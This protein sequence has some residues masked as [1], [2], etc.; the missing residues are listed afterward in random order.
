M[1]N[2][3]KVISGL[4]ILAVIIIGL[5]VWLA[6]RGPTSDRYLPTAVNRAVQTGDGTYTVGDLVNEGD[7]QD[8][9]PTATVTLVELADFE[10]PVCQTVYPVVASLRDQFTTDQLRIVYRHVPLWEIHTE[11]L[12]SARAAQAAQNQGKFAEY[13]AALYENQDRLG[14]DLYSELADR[15]ELDRAQFDADRQSDAVAWQASR[16]RNYMEAQGWSLSTPTITINGVR[17]EGA[18]TVTDMSAA[19]TAATQK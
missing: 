6:G 5:L 12:P 4:T 14:E 15:F 8:G 3:A 10:C 16:A 1:S 19:I 9:S 13:A 2:D 7:Y 17:Y 11:A 18:R